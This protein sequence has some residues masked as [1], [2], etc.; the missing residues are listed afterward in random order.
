VKGVL[1]KYIDMQ[2][3]YGIQY[4]PIFLLHTKEQV[5]CCGLLPYDIANRICE[6]G[7]HIRSAWWRQGLAEE[8]AAAVIR[9]AFATLGVVALFAGHNPS[10]KASQNLVRKLGF[11]YT[12]LEHYP[13][14][15]L[16]HPSYILKR[17]DSVH[18]STSE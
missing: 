6:L 1:Q 18:I 5:G 4:W 17:D 10:N 15:G 3:E 7:V 11:R 13:A 12:H 9:Y 2:R 8:A 16:D 14:T